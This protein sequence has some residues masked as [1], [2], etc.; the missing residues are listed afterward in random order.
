[1]HVVEKF[2]INPDGISLSRTYQGEDALYLTKA[3]TGEDKVFLSATP[4][5]P[6]ICEDLTTEIA[7]GH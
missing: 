3:F 1:M 5:E 2:T 6:Y 4:F 7:E